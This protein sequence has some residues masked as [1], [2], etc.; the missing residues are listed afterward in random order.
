MMQS[1]KTSDK[2]FFAF[3]CLEQDDVGV[4]DACLNEQK[5]GLL[6]FATI[7]CKKQFSGIIQHYKITISVKNGK[8][9]AK[10]KF[11]MQLAGGWTF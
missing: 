9:F 8:F 2:F 7:C 5:R 10:E 6:E 11:T 1:T 4:S 3:D